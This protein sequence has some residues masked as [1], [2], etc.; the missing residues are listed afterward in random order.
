MADNRDLS[1]TLE[2]WADITIRN[3]LAKILQLNL[4]DSKVLFDSFTVH[5]RKNSGGDPELVEFA[6]LYY[7]KF[8]DMGVGRGRPLDST[9]RKP[10]PWYNK[11]FGREISKLRTI[12]AEKYAEKASFAVVEVLM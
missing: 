4:I 6:F 11:T 9:L 2:A 12:L 5:I 8:V 1:L 7:G 10:H 3:W